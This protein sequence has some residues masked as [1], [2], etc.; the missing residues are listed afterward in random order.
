LIADATVA[1]PEPAVGRSDA[2]VSDVDP[3]AYDVLLDERM[4][5]LLGPEAG[6]EPPY[7]ESDDKLRRTE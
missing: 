6:C 3:M 4:A 1:A 7:D 5:D 2:F